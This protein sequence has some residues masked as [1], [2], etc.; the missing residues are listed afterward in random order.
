MS[1][2]TFI[3]ISDWIQVRK[4]I[5][6]WNLNTKKTHILLR[7]FYEALVDCKKS[8]VAS[9]IMVKLLG[10]YMENCFPGLS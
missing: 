4:W 7:L 9:K 1:N 2:R 3:R 8:D 6:D 5:S 10:S